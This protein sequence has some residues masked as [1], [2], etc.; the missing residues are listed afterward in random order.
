MHKEELRRKMRDIKRQFS[1]QQLEGLSLPI[2]GRLQQRLLK[3]KV[4]LAFYSLPD[5]VCIHSLL[6]EWVAEGKMVLLP[7]V[8]DHER[9]ELRVYTGPQDLQEG[10]FHLQ[11]PIGQLFTDYNQIDIALIPGIAFDAQG[12]RLGRGK[13]YY[14]RFLQSLSTTQLEKM[15]LIGVCFDFQKV[16]HVPTEKFDMP[17]DEVI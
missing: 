10:I 15:T 11:E 13:G 14:D 1:Q 4:I 6:D 16:Q 2:V 5:E 7:H 9:M 12:H 3:A 17:V 8:I